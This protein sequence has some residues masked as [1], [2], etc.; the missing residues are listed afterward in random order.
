M[1]ITRLFNEHPESVGE[2]YWQHLGVA[3]GFAFTLFL[4]SLAALAHALLPFLFVTTAS[5]KIEELHERM[6]TKRRALRG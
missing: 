5:R 1:Q 4:A 2:T 6:V 3:L